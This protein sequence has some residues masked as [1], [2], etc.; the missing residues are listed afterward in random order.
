MGLN[1]FGRELKANFKLIGFVEASFIKLFCF[2]FLYEQVTVTF[3]GEI[4]E[5]FYPTTREGTSDKRG[6]SIELTWKFCL[7][8]GIANQ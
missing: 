4:T 5:P 2:V 6:E 1:T 7:P 3:H 8:R